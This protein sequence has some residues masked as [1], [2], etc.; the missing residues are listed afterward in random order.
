[1]C[2]RHD[3]IV[4]QSDVCVD[5]VSTGWSGVYMLL[6]MQSAGEGRG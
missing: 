5:G 6:H 1:M 4:E 2:A 3:G